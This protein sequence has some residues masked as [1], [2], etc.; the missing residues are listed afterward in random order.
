MIGLYLSSVALESQKI[1]INEWLFYIYMAVRIS[2]ITEC[3]QPSP[4]AG[5]FVPLDSALYRELQRPE[6]M[7][8]LVLSII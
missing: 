5:F 7:D 2:R 1:P 6:D 8:P 3:S 4:H